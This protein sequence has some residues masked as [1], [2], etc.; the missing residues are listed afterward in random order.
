MTRYAVGIIL[1]G[2]LSTIMSA[3]AGTAARASLPSLNAKGYT[4]SEV[5][6]K[7]HEDIYRTWKNSLHALSLSDPVFD[8]AY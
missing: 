7:C 3:E 6:A 5:C 8:A 2:I 4:S 1:A